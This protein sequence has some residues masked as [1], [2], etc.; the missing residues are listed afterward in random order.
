MPLPTADDVIRIARLFA[1]VREAS[2]NRGL[3]VEAI[4]RWSGGQSGD[5]W[6]CE[7]ATMVLDIAY[8]GHPPLARSGSCQYVLDYARSLGLPQPLAPQPGDLYFYVDA[9]G[10]AHHVGIVT[11]ASP[12]TGIAGNTSPDG[13]SVNGTGVFEHVIRVAASSMVFV[14]YLESAS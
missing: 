12:L 7:F 3:R 9:S 2:P 4:Q 13:M 8:A 5:S 10:H 14:H 1:F 6:C 11:S